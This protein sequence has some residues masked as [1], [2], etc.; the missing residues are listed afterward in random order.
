M[1]MIVFARA[2]TNTLLNPSEMLF[3]SESHFGVN[4]NL[5]LDQNLAHENKLFQILGIGVHVLYKLSGCA[6]ACVV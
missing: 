4:V 5:D 3:T 1:A 6:C 2:G